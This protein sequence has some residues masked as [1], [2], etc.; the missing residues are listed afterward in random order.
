MKKYIFIVS[1]VLVFGSMC[2]FAQKYQYHGLSECVEMLGYG[3]GVTTELIQSN[4]YQSNDDVIKVLI[5]AGYSRKEAQITM[6]A[7]NVAWEYYAEGA[8]DNSILKH[9][10]SLMIEA[11]EE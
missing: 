3:L 5:N 10:A 2:V 4:K 1:F 6:N 7:V 9:I 11:F 8:L